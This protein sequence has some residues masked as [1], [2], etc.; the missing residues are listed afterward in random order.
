VVEA[1]IDGVLVGGETA[2]S[3]EFLSAGYIEHN[4]DGEGGPEGFVQR[5]LDQAI[6]YQ[7]RHYV[8][9]EGNFVF[10][11]S[12]GSRSGVDVA[13]YDLFR[14][15]AGSIAEHW[16]ARRNVPASTASGLGIF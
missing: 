16:D 15:E 5:I 4:S 14:V 7:T 11:L 3:S 2:L 9:A 13:F 10:V 8:I 12:E 6:S 1:F